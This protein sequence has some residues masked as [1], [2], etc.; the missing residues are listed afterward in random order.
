MRFSKQLCEIPTEID[1]INSSRSN[2]LDWCPINTFQQS[3]SQSYESFLG[4]KISI[5]TNIN[6]INEC[7]N[8]MDSDAGLF[9]KSIGSHGAPGSE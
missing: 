5:S 9:T 1:L 7:T 3:N 6:T 8:I 4:Q 2:L